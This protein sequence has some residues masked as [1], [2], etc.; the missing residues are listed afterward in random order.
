MEVPFCF[1]LK[2]TI[3]YDI[4]IKLASLKELQALLK[5]K[6]IHFK[7]F[8]NTLITPDMRGKSTLGRLF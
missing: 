4:W 2:L 7:C 1:F 5:S 6:N 8:F 3:K